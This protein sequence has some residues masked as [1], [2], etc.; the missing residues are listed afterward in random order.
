[1]NLK[2]ED[3]NTVL[4]TGTSRGIGL[5]LV[6]LF[7]QQDYKVLAVSR[8]VEALKE[9]ANAGLQVIEADINTDEG[10][11]AVAKAVETYGALDILINNAGAIVNKPFLEISSEELETVYRANVFAPYHLLQTL[12]PFMGKK[13]KGHVV[14][15]GSMG[16]FQGTAKFAGL[17]AY[18]SS[19]FALAGLTEILAEEFKEK[20]IA[21][22]C[23]AL[24]TAQTKMLEEAFP[25]YKAPVSAAE[26][27]SFI[28]DFSMKSH[29]FINGKII[30]VS[31][32]TP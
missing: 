23:L 15:I 25:G 4:I 26:M 11:K 21:F 24:G 31:L 29:H 12:I 16:G 27:A 14:N 3:M 10:R 17:T 18:S 9:I 20:N 28:V 22:N 6:K 5:E 1:M 8:H 7:L 19:K 30:P 13:S 32:S 2:N